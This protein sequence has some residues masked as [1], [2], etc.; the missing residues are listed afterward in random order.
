MDRFRCLGLMAVQTSDALCLVRSSKLAANPFGELCPLRGPGW[1]VANRRQNLA[2]PVS[3]RQRLKSL[4]SFAGLEAE[5][6]RA[7]GRRGRFLKLLL[8]NLPHRQAIAHRTLSDSPFLR[9][10]SIRHK[11]SQLEFT[12]TDQDRP[13]ILRDT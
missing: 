7:R 5:N 3:R 11:D 1:I 2:V 9:Y 4:A 13:G 8:H 12:P 10:G 6:L